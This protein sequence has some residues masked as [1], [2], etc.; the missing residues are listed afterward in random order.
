MAL[1]RFQKLSWVASHRAAPRVA[2][3]APIT[4][5]ASPRVAVRAA[6]SAAAVE[7]LQ[8]ESY[9]D[10]GVSISVTRESDLLTVR[11][12]LDPPRPGATLHW[13]TDDWVDT[14]DTPI[15]GG[16][17]ISRSFP[18]SD[19]CP[20]RMVFVIKN[21]DDSW[22]NNGGACYSAG[23]RAP[24]LAS[25]RAE[26]VAAEKGTGAWGIY[27]RL[28]MVN[29]RLD[30][31]AAAGQDGMALLLTWLRLSSSRQL[32]WYRGYNYQSKDMDHMQ[33]TLAERLAYLARR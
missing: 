19:A 12:A 6:S 5:T 13:G 32:T 10:T 24:G 7:V 30:A 27:P 22:D 23:L 8:Q 26:V 11:I 33:K 17:A 14:Q 21:A 2:L 3:L 28:A 4:R 16:S 9:P 15:E 31:F 18:D 29:G 1:F 25:V 20:G